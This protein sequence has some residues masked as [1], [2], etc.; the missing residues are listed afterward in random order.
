M[1][2]EDKYSGKENYC[3]V[4]LNIVQQKAATLGPDMN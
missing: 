4:N 1:S 3:Q 2:E